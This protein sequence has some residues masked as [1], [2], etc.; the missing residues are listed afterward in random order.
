MADF[1]GKQ[2][3]LDNKGLFLSDNVL[4]LKLEGV[5]YGHFRVETITISTQPV[6]SLKSIS[7]QLWTSMEHWDIKLISK[8]EKF[9][10]AHKLILSKASPVINAI[11]MSLTDFEED[12]GKEHGLQFLNDLM[13]SDIRKILQYIYTGNVDQDWSE[14]KAVAQLISIAD[15]YEIRGLKWLSFRNI[16]NHLTLTNFTEVVELFYTFDAAT[17]LQSILHQ[18]FLKNQ[19]KLIRSEAFQTFAKAKREAFL[20]VTLFHGS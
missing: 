17:V 7:S 4:R 10:K 3:L 8:D 11:L 19:E 15:T 18:F 9:I 5:L 20:Y 12:K 6:P 16:L 2:D 13:E 14:M 1:I